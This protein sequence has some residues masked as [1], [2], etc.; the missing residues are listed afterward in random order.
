MK[1][2]Y[3]ARTNEKANGKK[4]D[5]TIQGASNT[6]KFKHQELKKYKPLN[7]LEKEKKI[8]MKFGGSSIANAERVDEVAHIIKGQIEL[9][10]VP[11]AVICSAMGKTT[12]MLLSAGD[13]AL[14][15]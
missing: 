12:N 11:V 5:G 13:M 4:E 14:G 7:K 2:L 10:Y 1:S 6:I 9:G 3:F 8:T 15:E